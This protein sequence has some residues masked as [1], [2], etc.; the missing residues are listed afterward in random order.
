M[1]MAAHTLTGPMLIPKTVTFCVAITAIMEEET[2]MTAP[3]ERSMPAPSITSVC[4]IAR[5]IS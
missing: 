1:E 2:A 4:P 3:T 5:I